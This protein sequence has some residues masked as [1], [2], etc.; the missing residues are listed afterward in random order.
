MPWNEHGGV[1]F[2]ELPLAAAA[3]GIYGSF[4][5]THSSKAQSRLLGCGSVSLKAGVWHEGR[6]GAARNT[7][8]PRARAASAVALIFSISRR[9]IIEPL[10]AS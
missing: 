7:A 2:S 3:A 5:I 4:S 9:A 10:S 8:Q 1:L 6:G